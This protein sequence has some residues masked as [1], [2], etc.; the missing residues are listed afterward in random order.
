MQTGDGRK[1]RKRPGGGGGD[2]LTTEAIEGLDCTELQ[3]TLDKA[4]NI[5]KKKEAE[6]KERER[7]AFN[8][9]GDC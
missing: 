1:Y 6:A 5:A 9:C 3:K 8:P 7:L 2:Q 4:V